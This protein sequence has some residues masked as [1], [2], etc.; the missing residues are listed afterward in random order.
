MTP[1]AAS[2]PDRKMCIDSTNPRW[3]GYRS[4]HASGS[5]SSGVAAAGFTAPSEI[6][7]TLKLPVPAMAAS[8]FFF[9]FSLFFFE[10]LRFV[11]E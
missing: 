8:P 3:V 1:G 4:T 11:F 5:V 10:L 2:A 7:V 9:F 6:L